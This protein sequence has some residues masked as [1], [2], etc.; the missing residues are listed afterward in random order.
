[1]AKKNETPKVPHPNDPV[2][3][4]DYDPS[5][6]KEFPH[7]NTDITGAENP[8]DRENYEDD[9]RDEKGRPVSMR[10]T[11]EFIIPDDE[12]VD[13]EWTV[14]TREGGGWNKALDHPLEEQID[15]R[16]SESKTNRK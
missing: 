1:M 10:R 3:P 7:E 15:E 2:T 6:D 12:N 14:P 4:R 13:G 5:H 16:E 11:G 9:L 8:N